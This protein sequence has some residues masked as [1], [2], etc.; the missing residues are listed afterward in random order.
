MADICHNW[1]HWI[2]GL[3]NTETDKKKEADYICPKCRLTDIE[4]GKWVPQTLLR[5]KDRPRT[6]LSDHIEKRLFTRMKQEREETAKSWGK[7]LENVSEAVDL[8]VRVVV[9]VDKE[10]ERIEGVDACIFGMY[11]QDTCCREVMLS[12]SRWL[13]KEQQKQK[14][15]T[16]N[17]ALDAL[18]HASR[19]RNID[20]SYQDY[21]TIMRLLRHA[22]RCSVVYAGGGQD[23]GRSRHR[24]YLQWT[25]SWDRNQRMQRHIAS[26]DTNSSGSGSKNMNIPIASMANLFTE[27]QIKQHLSSFNQN[28]KAMWSENT[29]ASSDQIL[30]HLYYDAVYMAP[31][32][33]DH[34]EQRLFTR[35]KQ[36]REET[37]KSW[38]TELENVSE[39]VDLVVRVVE[40]GSQCNG[41]NN[42]CVY[43]SY[44]DSVKYFQPQRKTA[45]G[46]CPL[47]NGQ[48]YIFYYH[49][50]SQK[51]TKEE[52]LRQW[53]ELMLKKA[54]N[55]GIVVGHNNFYD[56]F[57]VPKREENI[58]ITAARL[59]Y[60]D[61]AF[62]SRNAE[63]L[64]KKL[65]KSL[66][67]RTL[68][69]L[70]QENPTN[71]VLVMQQVGDKVQDKKKNLM[72]VH[73]QHMSC[74]TTSG[75]KSMY[76]EATSPD[77]HMDAVDRRLNIMS[78]GGTSSNKA[79]LDESTLAK[80][81]K[82][83][84]P[85]FLDEL[86]VGVTGIIFV[87]LCRIWDVCTVT[88]RYLSTDMVVFDALGNAIH[89][90]ARYNVAH[91]FIKLKE[92]IIYCIKNFVVH[93][94]KE[95]YRIRKDDAFM[96]EFNGATSA[97][98]YLAKAV[99]FVRHPF[100]LVKLD[101]M[102]QDTLLMLEDPFN[103]EQAL[104]PWTST[105]PTKGVRCLE[106]HYEG[107]GA[108]GDTLIEKKTK[109]VWGYRA[110]IRLNDP[111]LK[112]LGKRGIECI[113]VGYVEHSTAF[114]FYVLKPND[115]VAI[116]SIIKS[117]DAIFDENRF[118]SVPRLSQK[119]LVIGTKDIGG[120]VVLKK[121]TEEDDPKALD[122]AMKF[123]DIAFWKEAINDEI[124]SIMGNN[125][126]VLADLTLGSKPLGCKWIF[127][128][129]LKVDGTVEKFKAIL[130]IHQMDVKTAFSHGELDEEV[131]MNQPQ[132][133]IMPGNEN[134]VCKLVKSPKQWHQKFDEVVLSN[135]YL[136][137]QA[138]KCVYSKFNES[139]KGVIICL[140]VDG[141]LIFAT[142]QVQSHYIK[143]VVKK[144][145][146]FNCTS[147]STPMD[148]S[149]KLVKN[150]G[151]LSKYTSNLLTQ[152]WQAIQQISNTEYN[153]Y[154]SGWV[155]Q[156]GGRAI[157]WASKKKTCITGSIMKSD[158]M[159]LA[160]AGKEAEWLKN[161]LLKIPLWSKPITPISI[162][163]DS[164]ATLE[165]AY[166]QM[167]NGK[168][169]H[170]GVRHSMIREPVKNRVVS[171]E[172]VRYQQKL[173]D[174]DEGTG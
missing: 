15:M 99:G 105:W 76:G 110:V 17:R 100:Q 77:N 13:N 132:G 158:I 174:H 3:F 8:V 130:I 65:D 137:N 60:F 135:G 169:R 6:N 85:L 62:W 120:L 47:L 95:E 171:I 59:T 113:F 1:Q 102:L 26:C 25:L 7:E 48:D 163:C 23:L 10:L 37:A 157:S 30:C 139:G 165:K 121:V 138:N 74:K 39:A 112:T 123:Q 35:M 40:Y 144:F 167:Y 83:D 68:K 119:S 5:A 88:G 131:Y 53:Y 81:L 170:I 16:L 92:G 54:S 4:D 12:G 114:R 75:K 69:T 118:S 24:V 109:D 45:S 72:I 55:E 57:F 107:G 14:V 133:F 50:E 49:P 150:K 79:T 2:C 103:N 19:C 73:L 78:G 61:G 161:L 20:C 21:Q 11:V 108:L 80:E 97:R 52:K 116:N 71:D 147:V 82:S 34:I 111:K 43:I 142:D 134:N 22:S 44:L 9:Y 87:M 42:R 67:K 122:E 86:Q 32:P 117:R 93:P 31:P 160:A 115:S 84:S 104:E 127:K 96:M 18:V 151:K 149:E 38:G 162:R 125:T 33:S 172:F 70:E 166:N 173:A 143:K 156:L 66:N 36:E 28:K 94:N 141:M 124:D 164:V 148:I 106:S 155:F 140:Y 63:A 128:R 153:S 58:K 89:C 129:K 145:N 126:W 51:T 146:Y 159:A 154:T 29:E 136:L 27:S 90:S 46:S 64:S 98:K 56:Q 168:S 152:H 41:S 101:S 91:N